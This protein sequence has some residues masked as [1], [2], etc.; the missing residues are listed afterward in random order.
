M[1][2]LLNLQRPDTFSV[3]LGLILLN[4]RYGLEYQQ[5]MAQTILSPIPALV[6]FFVAQR[7]HVQGIVVTV[8][9]G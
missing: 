2:P 3:Q 8:M 6:I 7:R 4:G 1:R 9:K 5:T